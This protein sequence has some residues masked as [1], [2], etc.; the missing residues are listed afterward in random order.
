MSKG[1][2]A[3]HIHATILSNVFDVPICVE[4]L[5]MSS[6]SSGT[7]GLNHFVF[8]PQRNGHKDSGVGTSKSSFLDEH[9]VPLVTLLYRPDHYDILYPR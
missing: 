2:E 7:V 9:K 1:K 5:D 4:T 3:G 6:S 8:I